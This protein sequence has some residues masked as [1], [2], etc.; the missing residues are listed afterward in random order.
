MSVKPCISTS[1]KKGD[2]AYEQSPPF[3]LNSGNH[4][5]MLH[6][7]LLGRYFFAVE[8]EPIEVHSRWK[9]TGGDTNG[10]VGWFRYG[11]LTSFLSKLKQLL[12]VDLP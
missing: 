4:L 7:Q 3:M 5:P 11:H 8:R 9:V 12:H 6:Q 2:F 10:L 1:I